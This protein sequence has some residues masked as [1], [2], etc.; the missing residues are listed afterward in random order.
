MRLV[1]EFSG[2]SLSCPIGLSRSNPSAIPEGVLAQWTLELS[3]SWSSISVSF[4]YL[5]SSP[6]NPL[7]WPHPG[8]AIAQSSP[9][10]DILKPEV[11]GTTP[12]LSS[13]LLS[14]HSLTSSCS[15]KPGHLPLL[16]VFHLPPGVICFPVKPIWLWP[17]SASNKSHAARLST[18]KPTRGPGQPKVC[19]GPTS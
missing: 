3:G 9:P 4:H 19:F 7:F 11:S 10:S 18:S 5:C 14:A 15:P 13:S 1:S 2:P 12:Y 6:P 8:L 17:L 16:P